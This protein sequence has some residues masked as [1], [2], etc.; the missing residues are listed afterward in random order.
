MFAYRFTIPL[1]QGA[2]VQLM[3]LGSS[4]KGLWSHDR[5]SSE[6]QPRQLCHRAGPKLATR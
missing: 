3:L 5:P 1:A 4:C 2:K 6:D